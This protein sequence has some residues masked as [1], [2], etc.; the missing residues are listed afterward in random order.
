MLVFFEKFGTYKRFDN[1]VLKMENQFPSPVFLIKFMLL[2][3][4]EQSFTTLLNYVE[5]YVESLIFM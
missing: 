1:I 4:N 2:L 3:W 5:S